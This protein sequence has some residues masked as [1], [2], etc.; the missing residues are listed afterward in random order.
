MK[1]LVDCELNPKNM[2]QSN[3]RTT[4][5]SI[6]NES[7]LT[8]APLF[9]YTFSNVNAQTN[10]SFE[11]PQLNLQTNT[12]S[13]GIPIIENPGMSYSKFFIT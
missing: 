6:S 13:T 1:R 7:G 4:V 12:S 8:N 9:T 10:S 3:L 11:N 2:E 5:I